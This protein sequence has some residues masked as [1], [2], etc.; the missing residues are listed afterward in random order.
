MS[1]CGINLSM[2]LARASL[3]GRGRYRRCELVSI[4]KTIIE[5]FQEQGFVA[6]KGVLDPT[7][8]LQPVVDEY[9]EVLDKLARMLYAAGQISSDYSKYPF[10]ERISRFIVETGTKYLT[11]F[12]LNL[13][14]VGVTEETPMHRGPAIFRLMRNPKLLDVLEMFLGP[15]IL[16]NPLHIIRIKPPERLLSEE[17]RKNPSGSIK[18]TL[19]HQDLW[20]FTKEAD[21]TNVLTVWI[22]ITGATI[23]MGCLEVVPGSH[24]LGE[25]VV[26]HCKPSERRP[27]LKGI[28]DEIISPN[29]VPVPLEAGGVLFLHKLTQHSSLENVSDRFRWSFDLRYQPAGQPVGQ[30][31]RPA[32]VA[33]SRSNPA[34][35]MTDPDEWS[36]MW[37][38]VRARQ[39][40]GQQSD[41]TRFDLKSPLCF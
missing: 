29:R 22:P 33:R 18:K 7:E 24:L 8:D 5:E 1:R 32:W 10:Y 26:T 21:E 11:H 36:E 35:E 6:V 30:A 2:V 41:H 37:R 19:W 28:P 38:Q 14:T 40:R 20:A 12:D 16:C 23:E 9:A 4:T 15:E 34:S 17:A 25:D 27:G 39:A 13:P 31:G 3:W